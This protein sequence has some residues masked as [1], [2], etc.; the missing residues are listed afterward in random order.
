MEVVGWCLFEDAQQNEIRPTVGRL[1]PNPLPISIMECGSSLTFRDE[2]MHW[3]R[4]LA[5]LGNEDQ[6]EIRAVQLLLSFLES[7]KKSPGRARPLY[8]GGQKLKVTSVYQFS[9]YQGHRWFYIVVPDWENEDWVDYV[10]AL[11][12]FQ[13]EALLT[14]IRGLSGR[15]LTGIR[16]DL[17]PPA[18]Q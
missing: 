6:G 12:T 14:R 7:L 17:K 18:R 16:N 11:T 8:L 9:H 10:Q 13:N 3:N 1:L 4:G 5:K 2:E 15:M